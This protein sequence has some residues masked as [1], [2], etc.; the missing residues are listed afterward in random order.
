M[1]LKPDVVYSRDVY[2][3]AVAVVLRYPAALEIHEP[4]DANSR[5]LERLVRR[6]AFSLVVRSHRF[7]GLIVISHAL[8]SHYES[9]R[10]ALKDKMLVAH[11]GADP[12]DG[13]EALRLPRAGDFNVG[14]VGSLFE[15][16]GIE[17]ILP[18]ARLC[19]WAQF[20]VVGGTE[21]DAARWRQKGGTA[22]QNIVFHSHI[23]N[24]LVPAVLRGFDVLLAPYQEVVRGSTT[25]HNLAPWM[26][27]LK[28]FEYMAAERPIVCSDLPVLREILED[29]MTALLCRA[30]CISD[31]RRALDTLR[32]DDVLRRFLAVNAR[33][34]FLNNYTWNLRANNIASFITSP[35][36][37]VRP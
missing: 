29:R 34:H 20:H 23:P 18:L 22:A 7:R 37:G 13:E 35:A 2:S 9:R 10:A 33:R 14:Y 32:G 21:S 27:P 24:R 36:S 6:L 16:K 15:G 12:S 17:V 31:W 5:G 30:D 25:S 26:S 8:K 3:V 4:F 28:L 19:N 1:R 11:D